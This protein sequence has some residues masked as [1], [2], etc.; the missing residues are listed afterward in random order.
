VA[1]LGAIF[2]SFAKRADAMLIVG[3]RRWAA[4]SRDC[5]VNPVEV[6]ASFVAVDDGSPLHTPSFER[7]S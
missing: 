5:V 3:S 1:S 2:E 6:M 4:S 7:S